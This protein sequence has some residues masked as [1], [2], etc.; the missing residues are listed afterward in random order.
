M[1]RGHWA[2]KRTIPASCLSQNQVGWKRL[3]RPL[4]ARTAGSYYVRKVRN[5][6]DRGLPQHW[7]PAPQKDGDEDTKA[8]LHVAELQRED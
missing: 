4:G 8:V 2:A 7:C 3:L 6:V 5:S 1:S